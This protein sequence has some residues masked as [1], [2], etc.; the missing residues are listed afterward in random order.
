MDLLE[1]LYTRTANQAKK[2]GIVRFKGDY[3]KWKKEKRKIRRS[4]RE[5]LKNAS[6]SI[7]SPDSD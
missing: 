2:L 6:K 7:L 1:L 4:D 3:E 5:C